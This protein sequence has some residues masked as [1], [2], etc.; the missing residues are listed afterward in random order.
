MQTVID[1]SWDND[2]RIL[3]T[4][5][6]GPVSLEGVVEWKDGLTRAFSLVDRPFKFVFD[7]HNFKAASMDVHRAYRDFVPVLLAKHSLVLSLLTDQEKQLIE[8]EADETLPVCK[9]MALVHHYRYKMEQLD[10]L[11]KRENQRY[12]F[13][14][15]QAEKWIFDF[16]LDPADQV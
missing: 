5:L 3:T 12:F 11:Y 13:N 10:L 16:T 4:R 9:A 8:N 7:N 1:S 15:D 2:N 6:K 14:C